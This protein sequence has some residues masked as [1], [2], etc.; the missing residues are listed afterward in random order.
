[1]TTRAEITA[2]MMK[3]IYLGDGVYC[4]FDGYQYVL[5]APRTHGDGYVALEPST[6]VAFNEARKRISMLWNTYYALLQGEATSD[7]APF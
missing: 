3:E 7:E 6:L 5:R 1:M 2:E 4:K